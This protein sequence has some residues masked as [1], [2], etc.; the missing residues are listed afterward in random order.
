MTP[1]MNGRRTDRT[2][3]AAT[4]LISRKLFPP[5][6]ALGFS[7]AVAA[8]PTGASTVAG[9]ATFTAN[10]NTLTVETDGRTIINWNSF[11]IGAA[12]TT[13]FDMSGADRAV[14]N[15]VINGGARSDILGRLEGNGRVYLINPNGVLIGQNGVVQTQSFIASTRDVTDA[16]FLAG[17]ELTFTGAGG[18]EVETL[19]VIEAT[20][21]DVALI[22]K[23]VVTGSTS[24]ITANQ[25]IVAFAA[26]DEVVLA[27]PGSSRVF[28]R[29]DGAAPGTAVNQ[30]D[31]QGSILAAQAELQAVGGNMFGLAVN[32]SGLINATGVASREGRIFLTSPGGRITVPGA[33]NAKNA[34]GSGGRIDI[35]AGSAW[36]GEVNISGALNVSSTSTGGGIFI[37]GSYI[38]IKDSAQLLASGDSTLGGVVNVGT[39]R[40]ANHIGVGSDVLMSASSNLDAGA[41]TI[42]GAGVAFGGSA[43]ARGSRTL[44]SVALNGGEALEFTGLADLR[45]YGDAPRFGTLRIAATDADFAI[46][47]GGS[48]YPNLLDS[49][50]LQNQLGYAHVDITSTREEGFIDVFAP[51][52]WTAPTR[53]SLDS[54]YDVQINDVIQAPNGTLRLISREG[55]VSDQEPASTTVRELWASAA[56]RV[57]FSRALSAEKV[58]LYDVQGSTWLDSTQ[59]HLGSV[60][61]VRDLA[62]TSGDVHIT[63]SADGLS[64]SVQNIGMQSYSTTGNFEVMTVG[65]LALE[66]SFRVRVSG[67]VT[68]LASEGVFRNRSTAGADVFGASTGALG[69]TRIYSR[70][71]GELG[72]L[73]GESRYGVSHPNDPE[74]GLKT[75]FYYS[76]SAPPVDPSPD[77][78]PDPTPNPDQTPD[79]EP[80][81]D[82]EVPQPP[83][84]P[85]AGLVPTQI[86]QTALNGNTFDQLRQVPQQALPTPPVMTPNFAPALRPGEWHEEESQ[87]LE[88]LSRKVYPEASEQS[89]TKE[90]QAGQSLDD[91]AKKD[92]LL[93]LMVQLLAGLPESPESARKDPAAMLAML[94]ASGRLDPILEQIEQMIAEGASDAGASTESQ[95]YLTDVLAANM[96]DQRSS[97][98][99]DRLRAQQQAQNQA[100]GLADAAQQAADQQRAAAIMS[101]VTNIVQSAVSAGQSIQQQLQSG[102]PAPLPSM[103]GK[104]PTVK[105][106]NPAVQDFTKLIP[107]RRPGT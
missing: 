35:D 84:G 74:S 23:R 1:E 106:G 75:V 93:Q 87:K 43:V 100:E 104:I 16:S 91:A 105:I 30:I 49:E 39:Q 59:N 96:L 80:G 82:P 65:D 33:L 27:Q 40:E 37:D 101:F 2:P 79:P 52:S 19:G 4:A 8:N 3:P 28:V 6:V 45:A 50:A 73:A 51:L 5:L 61:F 29:V 38:D 88:E 9:S 21:G 70:A 13:R 54:R 103:P 69:R 107:P 25:G 77:P 47:R 44:G 64:L 81:S 22:G 102:M 97:A 32:A 15:R 71:L 94:K 26:G 17:S 57:W 92:Q 12:E 18:G 11:S 34:D 41:I 55:S 42:T 60:I 90:F 67:D 31:H 53:L 63:D 20:A 36:P 66:D 95:Q 99:A 46:A 85:F 7:G 98:L 89:A 62:G 86:V 48:G 24:S 58:T 72:G 10:G 56:D 68:L 83:Q 14:L 76:G 78:N